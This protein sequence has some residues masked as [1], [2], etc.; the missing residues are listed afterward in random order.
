MGLRKATTSCTDLEILLLSVTAFTLERMTF[1][2]F[3]EGH[4]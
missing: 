1:I 3:T 4:R 2:A